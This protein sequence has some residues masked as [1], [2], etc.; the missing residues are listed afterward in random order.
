MYS[1][2][3]T[4]IN[5]SL[6]HK[7]A[8]MGLVCALLVVFLHVPR[9]PE[10]QDVGYRLLLL[11][12][13]GFQYAAYAISAWGCL[14]VVLAMSVT[15]LVLAFLLPVPRLSLSTSDCSA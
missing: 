8:N 3:L 13:T 12:G 1:Y 11:G 5:E 15:P 14:T 2:S 6:S 10:S 9:L 4:K 7:I